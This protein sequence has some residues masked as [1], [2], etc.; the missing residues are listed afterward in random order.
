MAVPPFIYGPASVIMNTDNIESVYLHN[1]VITF[2]LASGKSQDVVYDEPG[3]AALKYAEYVAILEGTSPSTSTPTLISISPSSVPELVDTGLTILG[4]NF[5]ATAVIQ[6]Q[7]QGTATYYATTLG[8]GIS[9]VDSTQLTTSIGDFSIDKDGTGAPIAGGLLVELNV[10]AGAIE[11]FKVQYLDDSPATSNLL[12]TNN[13][14]AFA[15]YG[16]GAV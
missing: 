16:T 1:E 8:G 4:T 2:Y 3:V 6:I 12:F 15:I 13:V 14:D 11:P 9:V 5:S 7:L 10:V